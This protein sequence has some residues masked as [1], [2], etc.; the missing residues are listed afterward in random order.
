[1]SNLLFT[2]AQELAKSIRQGQVSA[3]EVLESHLTQIARYNR[4]LNAI[5]TLDEERARARA[6]EAD[7]A[8]AR[9]EV[10]G[11]LH[12]VPIT[13]K[14]HWRLPACAQPA[15]FHRWRTMCLLEMHPQ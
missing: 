5:V 8:L 9:G 3:T 10:W 6:K 11:P 15:A 7:K 12:G 2:T 13:I 1:M 14:E 4:Q